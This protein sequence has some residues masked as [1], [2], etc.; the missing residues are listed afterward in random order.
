MKIIQ[1]YSIVNIYLILFV[2]SLI[3]AKLQCDE[4]SRAF[5]KKESVEYNVAKKCLES[6]PFNAKY[7]AKNIDSA[8]HFLSNYYVFF[9]RAKEK[10]PSGFTYQ[11][12]DLKSE[13]TSL[14]KKTFNSDYDFLTALRNILF[15]LKDGHTRINN[16][17]YQN[18]IYDQK[19][20]LYSVITTDK[21]GKKK[22]IIYVFNDKLDPSNNDCEV[23]EI[24]GKPALQTIVDFANDRIA[25]SKDLGVRF[26]MA[27]APS[28]NA[29]SQQFTLRGDLP[30]TSS[31]KYNLACPKNKSSTI[32][33]KWS[34]TFKDGFNAFSNFCFDINN[35]TSLSFNDNFASSGK[36]TKST[37]SDKV[38]TL[39]SSSENLTIAHAKKVAKDFYLFDDGKIKVGVAVITEEKQELDDAL[40]NGF[41][42]LKKRGAKKLIL[43]MSNNGGGNLKVPLFLTSLLLSSK[44]PNSFPTD[45]IIQNF[46]IQK[47]EKNFKS[48]GPTDYDI[49]NPNYYLSFPS[50]KSFKNASEFIGSRKKRTS[51]LY[52]NALSSDEKKLLKSTSSFPWTS[53]D[54]IIITNGFCA[55]ACALLTLFF[56]EIHKVKTI[57]V[58]GLLDTKMSFSTFPGGEVTSTNFIV[59]SAGDKFTDLPDANALIL[60][61]RESY[62][63][64]INGT[65]KDVL[66][67]S[68][69]PANYRLYYDEKNARDPSLLWLEAAKILNKKA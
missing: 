48:S 40:T 16:I 34:V 65:V 68:Y 3:D 58:G 31:I 12:V 56:S 66:E 13:L 61:I 28:L 25:Y 8:L 53:D 9:D 27:L 21:E 51:N 46:I 44:Q 18:F 67:Y 19:L 20:S 10:S 36:V 33:R 63:M 49:Y 55:S 32:E 64:D 38:E 6:Y 42:K 60:T 7:A 43:D 30:E 29:F 24:E 41:Q 54:I 69:K 45:I 39:K 11:P 57:A 15:K 52:L 14:R 2:V 22:Q 37:P 4:V 35:I 59:D 17:C 26:N 5:K 62:D 47:I 23:T 50:G 1:L